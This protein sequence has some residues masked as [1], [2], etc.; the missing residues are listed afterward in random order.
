MTR[1]EAKRC[2]LYG[3]LAQQVA[4]FEAFL[5][6]VSP[7]IRRQMSTQG[8]KDCFAI[9]ED[10]IRSELHDLERLMG[11][12]YSDVRPEEEGK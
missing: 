11:Y 3:A 9:I 4:Q 6:G 7:E 12:E 5:I 2:T 8:N 10:R 1:E